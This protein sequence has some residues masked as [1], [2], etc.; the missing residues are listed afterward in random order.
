MSKR[1]NE[2]RPSRGSVLKQVEELQAKVVQA[3]EALAQETVTVSAGGGAVKVTITGG[4]RVK[5][6]EIDPQVVDPQE[7]GML[8]ELIM[9]AVNEAIERSQ[10]LAA[11][12]MSALTGGLKIPGL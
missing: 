3:Q 4:Q 2:P 1:K 5:S 6:I 8:Q 11:Q 9:A 10:E 7:V 12:R